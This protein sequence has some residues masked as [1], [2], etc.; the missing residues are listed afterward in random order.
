MFEYF[1]WKF[2]NF[3]I[4]FFVIFRYFFL[5]IHFFYL[6]VFQCNFCFVFIRSI[7]NLPTFISFS[8]VGYV[9]II[10][11]EYS[12]R[13][14]L[15]HFND[16]VRFGIN[17]TMSIPIHIDNINPI[18]KNLRENCTDVMGQDKD[19]KWVGLACNQTFQTENWHCS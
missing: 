16:L 11:Y 2:S 8:F 15:T 13:I 9:I 3:N 18:L 1:N 17:W 12:V 14:E 7:F 5:M 19:F 10:V 4:S 6:L